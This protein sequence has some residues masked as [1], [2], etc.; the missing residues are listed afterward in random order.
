MDFTLVAPHVTALPN[1]D[2]VPVTC[3]DQWAISD[4]NVS[5]G[6]TNTRVWRGFSQILTLRREPS[7]CERSSVRLMDDK[8]LH[9]QSP[10]GREW[11][12]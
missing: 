9:G 6:L 4:C 7:G 5:K 12:E 3:L 2:C 11:W 1:V 8:K 10:G